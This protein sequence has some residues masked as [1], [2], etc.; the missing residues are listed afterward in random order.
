MRVVSS[1]TDFINTFTFPG[2]DCCLFTHEMIHD[3]GNLNGE[4][5]ESPNT[6][7]VIPWSL[8]NHLPDAFLFDSV[9]VALLTLHY[10]QNLIP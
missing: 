10:L 9:A 7:L 6:P 1:S 4:F 8:E 5:N 3:E 2:R